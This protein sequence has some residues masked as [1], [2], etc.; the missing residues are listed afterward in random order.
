MAP[1]EPRR[2]RTFL[3][4]NVL[5]YAHRGEEPRRTKADRVLLNRSRIFLTSPY[6]YLETAPKAVF[7]QKNL[8]VAFYT[9]F[10]E[11]PQVEWVKDLGGIYELGRTWA[12]SYGLAA[13]DAL[14]VAAAKLGNADEFITADKALVRSIRRAQAVRV[15]DLD[16]LI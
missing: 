9:Q 12:E 5:I 4:A 13:M 1:P 15:V 14:H 10:F 3:D 16:E 11:N 2:I 7:Q 8:E 6:V